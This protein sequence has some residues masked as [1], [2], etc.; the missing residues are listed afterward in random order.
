MRAHQI[1]LQFAD[2]VAGNPYFA[3]FADAGGDGVGHLIVGDERVDHGAR[4]VHA[5]A[6]VRRQ[7]HGAAFECDFAHRFE[8]QI[9]SADV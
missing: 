6:C 4:G 1:D 5:L 8:G 9:I 3:Q 7:Q 2:L